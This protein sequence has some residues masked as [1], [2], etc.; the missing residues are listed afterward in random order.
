[1]DVG[2]GEGVEKCGGWSSAK[3]AVSF[4]AQG[5]PPQLTVLERA[6]CHL[7]AIWTVGGRTLL[8]HSGTDRSPTPNFP[9]LKVAFSVTIRRDRT[10][11]RSELKST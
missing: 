6:E 1:M 9:P 10:V 3:A 11:E 2:R 7:P 4:H 8:R 5:L